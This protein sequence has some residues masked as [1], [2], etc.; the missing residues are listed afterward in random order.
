MINVNIRYKGKELSTILPKCNDE[1]RADLKKA[2]I[3]LPAEKLKLRSSAKEQYL[4]GLYTNNPLDDLIIDRLCN[5]DNLFELNNLCGVLDN[6][7]D[8]ARI[9]NI[10]NNYVQNNNINIT[11]ND[12]EN[13]ADSIQQVQNVQGDVNHYKDKV[14]NIIGNT[15]NGGFSLDGLFDWFKSF[16]N[17]I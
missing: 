10:I 11:N 5:N 14:G 17:G 3:D 1:L 12:I 8:H 13:L 4:V 16:I 7:T 15:T 6:V 2:G 9:V